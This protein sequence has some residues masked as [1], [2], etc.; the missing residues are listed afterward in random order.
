MTQDNPEHA[1][2]VRASYSPN[3]DRSLTEAVLDA[4]EDYKGEDLLRT[5]FILFED[6]NPDAL[7][8]LFRR[9]AQPRTTVAFSTDG[10]DVELWGDGGIEIRV[11]DRSIE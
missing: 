4:I 9:D 1:T 6:V 11:T 7:D 2:T 5:D 8:C 10:V 3:Q